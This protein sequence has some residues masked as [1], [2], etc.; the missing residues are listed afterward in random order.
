MRYLFSAAAATAEVGSDVVDDKVK[1]LIDGVNAV[2]VTIRD[3]A[4]Q[5][6]QLS[7]LLDEDDSKLNVMLPIRLL[8][9]VSLFI[10]KYI[11]LFHVL[12]FSFYH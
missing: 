6:E 3:G 7:L 12:L 8:L 10:G 9:F 4:W 1:K 11:F 2:I 5:I